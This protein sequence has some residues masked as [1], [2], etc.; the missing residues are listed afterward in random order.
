MKPDEQNPWWMG[1]PDEKYEAW[2]SK[3]IKWVPKLAEKIPTGTPGLHFL[4]GPRQVGKTTLLKILISEELN[5]KKDPRAL[6]YCTC[7]ELIDHRELGETLDNYLAMRDAR[8]IDHSLILLDEITLV[9]DWWRAI[10]ARIDNGKIARDTVI[11]S[12]SASIELLKEK[13]RF[14]G[15]R[16]AGQDFVLYPLS[17]Q[18]FAALTVKEL[19]TRSLHD[20]VSAGSSIDAFIAPNRVFAG[21]LGNLFQDYLTAGGFPT[22]VQDFLGTRM[23]RQE[24]KRT[25]LDWVRGEVRRAEKS[26]GFMKEII[27]YLLRTRNSPV[28]WQSITRETSINSPHTVQSY[29]EA[30][31]QL[32]I[33]RILRL[34]GPDGKIQH[35]KNK[36]F[37][38]I[39]PFVARILADYTSVQILDETLVES[40]VAM[41]VARAFPTYYWRNSTEVDVIGLIDGTQVGF[42]VKWGPARRRKPIHLKRFFQLVQDTI[43]T[44]LASTNW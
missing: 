32:Y 15:R 2:R 4:T 20:L 31:E 21:K 41:H 18:D 30:L 38:F 14:P 17:F 9:E 3:P 6:F 26:D 10:K 42:E 1:E 43:P 7:D 29:I 16:G 22:P 12:G 40:T 36:K 27:A 11:I 8:K 19:I 35:R 39:D 25:F 5:K 23:I 34:I 44:F 24:T 33:G 13:E 28:S 37:H